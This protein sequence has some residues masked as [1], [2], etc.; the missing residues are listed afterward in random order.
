MRFPDSLLK[1]SEQMK[2]LQVLMLV[3]F[4]FA[5]KSVLCAQTVVKAELDGGQVSDI[6]LE[7][8]TRGIWSAA[9]AEVVFKVYP[10]RI[11]FSIRLRQ[12]GTDVNRI[13][14]HLGS[15]GL[16][17]PIILNMYNRALHGR[18]PDVETIGGGVF[19]GVSIVDDV[20]I[21]DALK[22]RG[23]RN[24]DDFTA[25]LLNPAG[26]TYTNVQTMSVPGGEVRGQ[27]IIVIHEN[28]GACQ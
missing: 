10:D 24:F 1:G 17:G 16:A 20:R 5:G 26:L 6:N 4:F 15:E 13:D 28:V 8:F 14:V 27:N 25:A 21:T 9:T 11:E 12:F 23:I 18:I 3:V 7:A 22:R 2:K 19:Y